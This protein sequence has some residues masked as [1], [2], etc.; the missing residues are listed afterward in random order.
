MG[1]G[2]LHWKETKHGSGSSGVVWQAAQ[3][4]AESG[5]FVVGRAVKQLTLVMV[6]REAALEG[7]VVKAAGCTAQVAAIL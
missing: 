3:P 1:L 2:G 5:E 4:R 7:L 6:G